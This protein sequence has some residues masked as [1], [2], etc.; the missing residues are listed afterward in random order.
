M[1]V[2]ETPEEL[3]G[4]WLDNGQ[5]AGW[6]KGASGSPEIFSKQQALDLSF[7]PGM[8]PKR[9][10]LCCVEEVPGCAHPGPQPTAGQAQPVAAATDLDARMKAAGMTPLSEMLENI[11]L[12]RFLTHTGVTDLASFEA[13]LQMRREE[14][15][16]MQAT[17][18]LDK[19]DEDELFEWV[20]AHVA[21]FTEVLCNF[22]AA[23]DRR[24]VPHAPAQA[25]SAQK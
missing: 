12:G 6:V 24:G 16:R 5:R 2:I 11:P 13:W 3:Y 10:F 17:L 9:I 15:L 21:V 4:V 1:A 25:S 23:R 20:T 22:Q 14:L 18:T 19:R 8:S 7:L